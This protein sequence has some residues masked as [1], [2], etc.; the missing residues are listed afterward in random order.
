MNIHGICR[1]SCF[2]KEEVRA[3]K[4]VSYFTFYFY[5]SCSRSSFL[6]LLF[7]RLFISFSC[8]L[9]FFLLSPLPSFPSIHIIH[10]F[11]RGFDWCRATILLSFSPY[12]SIGVIR[13]YTGSCIK[14]IFLFAL[15]AFSRGFVLVGGC[16]IVF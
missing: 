4:I 8:F 3:S 13:R 15:P 14:I 11:D 1:S 9:S 5:S 10:L 2:C 12:P 16:C 6:L 7:D